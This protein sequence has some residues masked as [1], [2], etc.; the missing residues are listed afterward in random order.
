MAP[1]TG[2]EATGHLIGQRPETLAREIPAKRPSAG[3]RTRTSKGR[4]PTGPKPAAS[5]NSAT[6]AWKNDSAWVDNHSMAGW[7]RDSKDLLVRAAKRAFAN[8][9]TDLAAAV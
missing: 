1:A 2:S 4:S 6:P 5:S 7:M 3:E 9:I 8:N